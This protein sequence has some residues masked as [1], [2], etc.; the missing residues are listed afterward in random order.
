MPY[1]CST[2]TSQSI[3]IFTFNVVKHKKFFGECKGFVVSLQ[4]QFIID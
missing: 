4:R 2:L 1:L 3:N